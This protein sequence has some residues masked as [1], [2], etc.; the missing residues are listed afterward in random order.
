MQ[1][2]KPIGLIMPFIEFPNIF[3][4]KFV[5]CNVDNISLIFNW[6]KR[7]TKKDEITYKLIQ[8]LHLIEFALPCKIFVDHSPRRSSWQTI[9]VDNF[10]RDA[11]VTS[12]DLEKIQKC[13]KK[14]LSGALA[15]WCKNPSS[16]TNL[17]PIDIVNAII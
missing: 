10:S 7:T 2:W 4:G 14:S 13:P 17:V 9:L 6:E 11:T 15:A 16:S 3:A 5:K 1:F 12:N 8:T